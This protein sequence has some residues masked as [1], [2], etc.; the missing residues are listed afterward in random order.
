[1]R[2][3]FPVAAGENTRRGETPSVAKHQPRRSAVT[4]LVAGFLQGH[5]LT[6]DQCIFTGPDRFFRMLIRLHLLKTATAAH[7]FLKSRMDLDR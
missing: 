5:F 2:F 7:Y 1:M 6:A 3:R 4:P